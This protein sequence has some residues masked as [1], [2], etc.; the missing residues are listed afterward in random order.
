VKEIP[1]PNAPALSGEMPWPTQPIPTKPTPFSNQH[2][3]KADLSKI[4]PESSV[5]ALKQFTNSRGGLKNLP[6]SIKQTL[7]YGFGG[8]AEWG[9]TATDPNGIMY[10][11]GNNMLWIH[12][13]K[14]AQNSGAALSKGAKIFNTH[15]GICHT[16]D[17][18]NKTTAS[19]YPSLYDVSKRL[20]KEQVATL[21]ETGR[22]RMPSFQHIAKE[23]RNALIDFLWDKDKKTTPNPPDDVHKVTKVEVQKGKDFPY[24]PAYLNNGFVQLRDQDNYPAIKPPWGTLNAVDLNT[25]EYLWKVPLGEYPELTKKGILNTGTENHGGPVVTAGGLLFI[26]AT[27]DEKLRAFDTKTGKIVWE[28]KLPAGGFATPITYMVNGKQYVAIAAGGNRYGLKPGG[29]YVA[30][31]L[32]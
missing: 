21:L 25:G 17:N 5:Y 20:T 31:A 28:Y 22:N 29:K 15:C 23:D 18:Q 6:P 2:F 3:S 12:K 7:Y 10:V 14:S 9:G 30:F 1:V 11:N 32:P 8:G 27:Y 16:I 24:I 4:S 13:M 26:A 19:G